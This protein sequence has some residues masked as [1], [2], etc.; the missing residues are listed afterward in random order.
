MTEYYAE[1]DAVAEDLHRRGVEG[2]E[3]TVALYNGRLIIQYTRPSDAGL[4]FAKNAQEAADL[5]LS[6]GVDRVHMAYDIEAGR[7]VKRL[8]ASGG[9]HFA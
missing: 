2:R 3:M 1:S 7:E 8:V 4:E 9:S 6:P 5:L